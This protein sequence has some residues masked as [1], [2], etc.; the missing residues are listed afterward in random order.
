MPIKQID[1]GKSKYYVYDP[2]KAYQIYDERQSL[3]NELQ[4][5][6]SKQGDI[7]LEDV[8]VNLPLISEIL[9]RVDKRREY[10]VIYH[11][12]MRMNEFKKT[13][14]I[15]FW[16]LKFKPFCVIHDDLKLKRKYEC[17]NEAFC[18]FLLLSVLKKAS[19]DRGI[20]HLDISQ[21]YL[22]NL[23]HAFRYWDLSK[24]AIIVIAETLNEMVK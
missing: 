6:I 14:L 12:K 9:I 15:I 8:D 23:K 20:E 7:S 17:I 10:F 13:A 18:I 21:D 11:N 24:E 2:L 4:K 19:E 1:D 3:L 22:D 16:I 5:Y